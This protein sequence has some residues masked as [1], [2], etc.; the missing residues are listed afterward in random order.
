MIIIGLITKHIPVQ[1]VS[2]IATCR[3]HFMQALLAPFNYSNLILE[4]M[5]PYV[6]YLSV[7]LAAF[8]ISLAAL[9][10]YILDHN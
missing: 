10:Q 6:I 4:D 3:F 7:N 9:Q 8:F 5:E 1:N 2:F